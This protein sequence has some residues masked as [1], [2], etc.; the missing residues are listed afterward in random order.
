MCAYLH[1]FTVVQV[2][3]NMYIVPLFH[4]H[5]VKECFQ[6]QANLKLMDRFSLIKSMLGH[7]SCVSKCLFVCLICL[8]ES[9]LAV[10]DERFHPFYLFFLSFHN[11]YRPY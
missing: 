9:M 11:H 3:L 8:Y 7:L 6:A 5:F 4:T 1:L 2:G 10:K